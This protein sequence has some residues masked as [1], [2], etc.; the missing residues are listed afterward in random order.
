MYPVL[1][2]A[3]ARCPQESCQTMVMT[4]THPAYSPEFLLMYLKYSRRNT[5]DCCDPRGPFRPPHS[6]VSTLQNPKSPQ[7][8]LLAQ[9]SLGALALPGAGIKTNKANAIYA[10]TPSCS[11][12]K[13]PTSTLL[14]PGSPRQVLRSL[15][16][17]R[18]QAPGPREAR[19][20]R[21]QEVPQ[22]K[23]SLKDKRV[24]GSDRLSWH[25]KDITRDE[26]AGVRVVDMSGWVR[27]GEGRR[28]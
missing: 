6:L 14:C 24:L 27:Q 15:V 23:L 11:S 17:R 7:I 20:R 12:S 8:L 26:Q 25:N 10:P 3:R 18:P 19:G 9:D 22:G 5:G 4:A 21:N 13:T 16:P 2:S 28:R 1:A